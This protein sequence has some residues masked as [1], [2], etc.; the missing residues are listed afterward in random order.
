MALPSGPVGRRERQLSYAFRSGARGKQSSRETAG[1]KPV[2]EGRGGSGP[3]P[4]IR[5]PPRGHGGGRTEVTL[6]GNV[7]W[8]SG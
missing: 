7:S 2:P 5:W 1:R 4:E 8:K 3:Q 6:K